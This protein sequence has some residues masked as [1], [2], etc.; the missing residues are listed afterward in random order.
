MNSDTNDSNDSENRI[1]KS[2]QLD[3][4]FTVFPDEEFYSVNKVIRV[5]KKEKN[6]KGKKDYMKK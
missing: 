1:S 6:K 2:M 5:K 4:N 3:N